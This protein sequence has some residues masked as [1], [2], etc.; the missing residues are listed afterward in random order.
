MGSRFIRKVDRRLGTIDLGR[1]EPISDP[2]QRFC[3]QSPSLLFGGEG[4]SHMVYRSRSAGFARTPP[5]ETRRGIYRGMAGFF[6]GGT[7]DP[8][9]R[10]SF[11]SA[12]F[13]RSV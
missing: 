2:G 3:W 1:E 6:P 9:C 4:P 5:S 11:R 7:S 8:L 12:F 13:V 10:D